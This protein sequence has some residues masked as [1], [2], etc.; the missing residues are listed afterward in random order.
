MVIPSIT[1]TG[2]YGVRASYTIIRG[3][4]IVGTFGSV[5]STNPNFIPSLTY[6]DLFDQNGNKLFSTVQLN[7]I[8]TQPFLNF[9]AATLNERRVARNIDALGE[10]GTLISDTPLFNALETT[11]RDK[12]T[13]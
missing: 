9:Q 4:T 11:Q 12:Q 3:P 1:S 6:P 8:I 7:L 5:A 2:F 13:K 10:A